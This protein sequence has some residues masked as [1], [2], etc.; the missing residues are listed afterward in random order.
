MFTADLSDSFVVAAVS[1]TPRF[2]RRWHLA[3]EFLRKVRATG[4]DVVFVEL[5]LGD[6]KWMS[7]SL[8]PGNLHLRTIEEFWHKENC[9]QLG[10]NHGLKLWPGKKRVMWIDADCEPIGKTF[11]NWFEETWHELQHYELVQMWEWLQPLD[12]DHN[13]LGVANPSFMSNYIKFG[14]PYPKTEP[15]YPRRWGSPGL[16]WG[17]NI[18][19]LMQIGGLP[20]AGISGAGDWYFAHMLTHGLEIPTLNRYTPGYRN[21]WLQRQ[22]LCERWIK[23]DVGYVKGMYAHFFHGPIIKR[24][25]GSREEI[26][27]Q[28]DFDPSTDLK[29]DFQ[30]LWQLETWLPRQ[31]K[32]RDGLRQYF[33]QRNEDSIDPLQPVGPL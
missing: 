21:Y 17:A 5:A 2:K 4:I 7:D 26:L 19:P 27:L 33:R 20:D 23:R 12:I 9:L 3:E 14:T 8:H 10:I 11:T 24:G 15:G 29:R 32:I 18:G 30:G 25:Y 22:E 28:N 6:R 1:N 13:P 31:I 16:A